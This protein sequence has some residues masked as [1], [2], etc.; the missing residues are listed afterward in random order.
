MAERLIFSNSVESLLKAT[1]GK[2]SSATEQRLRLLGFGYEKKLE[3]AYP[4]EAWAEAVR[5]ISA[6]LYPTDPPDEQIGRAHV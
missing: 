2:V 4:A 3:P 1:R 5:L 6:E